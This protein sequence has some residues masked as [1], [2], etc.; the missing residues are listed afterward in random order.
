MVDEIIPYRTMATICIKKLIQ[1]L[2]V[3]LTAG[4]KGQREA[5]SFLWSTRRKS[6]G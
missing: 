1:D 2:N 3:V 6:H 4:T 5:S